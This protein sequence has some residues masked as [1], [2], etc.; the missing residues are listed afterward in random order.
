MDSATGVAFPQF[1]EVQDHIWGYGLMFSGL[2]IAY[3]IWKYGWSRYRVWQEENDI[4]GF[5]MRDYLDNGVSSFRDDFI[6]T[7]DN[8]WW[9]GRWWDY[10]MYLGFPLMFSVLMISY[11]VDLLVNVHDP[12]EPLQS[13][14][15]IHHL[16]FLGNNRD[17]LH[18]IE[19]VRTSQQDG[20]NRQGKPLTM[21]PLRA[22]GRLR[23]GAKAAL[24]ERTGG[25]RGAHRHSPRRG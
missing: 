3:S 21:A 14:R 2:F 22:L 7:G 17:P 4:T 25:R 13:T 6:N 20:P 11:F 8:D 15:D 12:L 18:R 1:L 10:I 23:A 24:Q 9:I 19:Q 5:S 16:P